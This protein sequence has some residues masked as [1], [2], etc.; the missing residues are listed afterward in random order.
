MRDAYG[1]SGGLRRASCASK[2]V[3]WAEH[4]TV[5]ILRE[6]RPC[7]TDRRIPL[8]R[9]AQMLAP[10][11]RL[12]T[13]DRGLCDREPLPRDSQLSTRWQTF[14]PAS[15]FQLRFRSRW[16]ASGHR[17]LHTGPPT[18]TTAG[19]RSPVAGRRSRAAARCI[20]PL[21]CTVTENA[22][23]SPVDS[24]LTKSLDLNSLG[25]NS[26]KKHR[27]VPLSSIFTFQLSTGS[28]VHNVRRTPSRQSLPA[29]FRRRP[30]LYPERIEGCPLPPYDRRPSFALLLPTSAATVP[31]G[32]N[33][34]ILPPRPTVGSA[35]EFRF[36]WTRSADKI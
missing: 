34:K 11:F 9:Q 15:N 27:G 20:S 16:R 8:R 24:T 3:R 4:E 19:H 28:R 13:L 25:M 26:Y 2:I 17:S 35:E 21:Q 32:D 10:R 5:I 1:P 36:V 18:F 29:H 14:P 31:A 6:V 12:G 22:P 23:A 7:R 33:Y 30:S